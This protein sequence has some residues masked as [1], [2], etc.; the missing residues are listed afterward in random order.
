MVLLNNSAL[1]MKL[2]LDMVKDKLWNEESRRKNVET[3]PSESD[4]PV[5]EKQKRQGRSQSINFRQQNNDNAK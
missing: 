4:A 5:L 2:T 1:I 3:V